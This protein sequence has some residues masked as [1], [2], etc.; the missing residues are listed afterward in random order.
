MSKLHCDIIQGGRGDGETVGQVL[1]AGSVGAA[2][3][4]R[5]LPRRALGELFQRFELGPHN[6]GIVV[7]VQLDEPGVVDAL[8]VSREDAGVL[9][10]SFV[11]RG[12]DARDR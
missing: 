5:H 4:W 8:R 11:P 9:Y 10:Q 7:D 1:S 6:G 12:H 3:R 2:S